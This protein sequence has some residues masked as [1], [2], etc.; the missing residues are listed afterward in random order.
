[1]QTCIF[2]QISKT[3]LSPRQ[4]TLAY[5]TKMQLS[6]KKVYKAEP[7]LKTDAKNVISFVSSSF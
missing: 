1:M 7:R 4:N 6:S 5:Y 2:D 3:K